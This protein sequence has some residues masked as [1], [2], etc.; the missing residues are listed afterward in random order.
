MR[1]RM[2]SI[3]LTLALTLTLTPAASAKGFGN[4]QRGNPYK[5][6]QFTDVASGAWYAQSVQTAYEMGLFQGTGPNTFHPNG[7]ISIAETIALACRLHSIYYTGSAD[8]GVSNPWYQVYVDYAIDNGIISSGQ[9]HSYNAAATRAQ[10]ASILANSL[11][12]EALSAINSVSKGFIPDVPATAD[13]AD[14]VYLLYNAGVLAGRDAQ[15]SFAPQAHIQRCEAATIAGRMADPSLR[16][17][18]TL[19]GSSSGRVLLAQP[20][21]EDPLDYT[22]TA[23]SVLMQDLV[24][25]CDGG[26]TYDSISQSGVYQVRK[27]KGSPE[28][29]AIVD[30]YVAVLTGGGYNL[31]LVEEYEENY[32]STFFSWGLDYTGTGNVTAKT[33]VVY[34]DTQATICIYGTI[35]RSKL[36]VTVWVPQRMEL[37]DLG[38]RYG[39]ASASTG[40][41]GPSAMAGLYRNADG[42]FETSDGR[43]KTQ[44]GRATVLRDGVSCSAAATFQT[45][46]SLSRDELWVDS[47]Y[48]NEAL[49]FCSPMDVLM[50]GDVYTQKDLTQE[51]SWVNS[52]EFTSLSQFAD[53][54]WTLF[55]GLGHDGDFITPLL[56]ERNEFQD[57]TV[58]VMYYKP[59]VEAVYYVYAGLDSAPRTMEALIAVDLDVEPMETADGTYSL[60]AGGSAAITCPTEFGTNYDTFSWEILS[61]SSVVSLS[62][63]T[64]RTCTVHALR[65]GT[66]RVRVTYHYGVDE[67]D[68]LTGIP[69][70]AD[71]TKT[72][73]YLIQV[74]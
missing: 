68:V 4:F 7:N 10:F 32:S 40:I 28:D 72:Y 17:T 5:S 59:G 9:Y 53:Y 2:F 47:F 49:F 43:L 6:G 15:G 26:L 58:R 54:R 64:S 14:A 8:L 70:N 73:E 74:Q 29:K 38:L 13:Y 55:F 19:G 23:D 11:D 12:R 20:L 35:K 67:P 65:T 31:K 1:R 41:A 22:V 60:S 34:T 45:N 66:A 3:L 51:A 36:E 16:T 33:D 21:A 24:E 48:R 71:K 30:E 39:S 63:A 56:G 44:L 42:S 25:F 57:L 18:F 69:R 52:K 46:E 61:G 37:V 50:T 27:F 62:G